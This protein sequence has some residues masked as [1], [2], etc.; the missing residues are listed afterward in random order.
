MK[1]HVL[2]ESHWKDLCC[3]GTWFVMGRDPTWIRFISKYAIMSLSSS[4]SSNQSV[5]VF[6]CEAAGEQ[7]N[8][9]DRVA[10]KP[11]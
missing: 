4:L 7:D 5:W 10:M 1:Q 9:G 8:R 11:V 3:A 6:V 2:N